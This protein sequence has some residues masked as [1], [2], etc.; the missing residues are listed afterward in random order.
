[1]GG[2]VYRYDADARS[3]RK[4][5]AYFDGKALFGEWNQNKMY[6]FQVDADGTS[7]VDINQL[8]TGMTL[9]PP[10]GLRVRA[11]TARCT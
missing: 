9:H 3:D 6:T 4:W 2:P 10:D 8:L 11:R 1:M 7:L 5:P